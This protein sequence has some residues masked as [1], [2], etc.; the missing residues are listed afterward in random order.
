MLENIKIRAGLTATVCVFA[1]LLMAV[2]GIGYDT[3]RHAIDGFEQA[4]RGA[5]AIESL[6]ASSEKLLQ[7][8]LA[9]SSYE[10]KF[11]VG[12]P[13]DGLL[14]EAH[15]LLAQSNAD[16]DAYAHRRFESETQRELGAQVAA[17]RA[18]LV[19]KAI[20]PEYKALVG[21][22][23]A[24]FRAIQG[25]IADS[26][27]GAYAKAI[28][29]LE[30][31]QTNSQH[32]SADALTRRVGTSLLLFGAIGAAAI[33]LGVA[34]RALLSRALVK[35]IDRAIGHF[36]RIAA[37][38]LTGSIAHGSSNEM[39]QLLGA[40]R[41]MRDGL[42]TTVAAVRG[43]AGVIAAGVEEIAAGNRD[44]SV[45][46]AR[47]AASLEQTASTMETLSSTVKENAG[48]AQEAR[49][50]AS[51]ALETVTRGG[52]AVERV[53]DTMNGITASSRKVAEIT[54]MI[55]GIAFQ[56]NILS[57]NAAVEAARAGEQGR[58][59]A[60]VAS[61]VRSL[62][63][64]AATA[65]KEIKELLG[66]S[67]ARIDEG[68]ALVTVAGETMNEAMRAVRRVTQIVVEIEAAASEQRAGIEAVNGAIGQID[69][70]TQNNV[71]LVE[72]AAA[73]AKSLQEQATLLLDA[74]AAFHLE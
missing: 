30:A 74:V 59:F 7:V 53:I 20:E 65:A 28:G 6:H 31:M 21:G 73:A 72:Q 27:Y 48:H 22:D 26:S 12:K 18:V 54:G 10:I 64:R 55:E 47:Q 58:G 29:A 9:L 8:R 17:A 13:T 19:G 36:G 68:A 43:G 37:G 38:D 34:A 70:A 25:D 67:S 60:V 1:A 32:A 35:P 5:S 4:Q 40:L 23:F 39:G 57:L 69:D 66:H 52:E 45:R 63:Q 62:A 3:L 71:A 49:R 15:R 16:F 56:T 51:G 33:A 24:T 42:A 50:L 11:H 2:I 46:T 61:E 14:D 44:L 41:Q